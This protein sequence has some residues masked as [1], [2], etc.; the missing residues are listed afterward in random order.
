MST[1]IPRNCLIRTRPPL[2]HVGSHRPWYTARYS[3]SL[4]KVHTSK[5]CYGSL[6][7]GTSDGIPFAYTWIAKT[8]EAIVNT[9]YA[10]LCCFRR[11]LINS[12]VCKR[13][14]AISYRTFY[15][16]LKFHPIYLHVFFFSL[17]LVLPLGLNRT[18]IL[19][20]NV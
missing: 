13:L 6:R 3:I 5:R 16:L 15:L 4:L 12:S 1:I 8:P 10:S 9:S 7:K 14:Q 11:T 18:A 17:H 2:N 20:E 19:L